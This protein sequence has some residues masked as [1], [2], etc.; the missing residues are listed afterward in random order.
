MQAFLFLLG[1]ARK[2]QVEYY[3]LKY[4]CLSLCCERRGDYGG[5]LLVRQTK[6]LRQLVK[7]S[8]LLN[9][10]GSF[11]CQIFRIVEQ[12]KLAFSNRSEKDI[13]T[14]RQGLWGFGWD[15]V[16]SVGRPP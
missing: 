9:G 14:V 6:K 2:R 13:F 16:M 4:M 10:S 15:A 3:Q 12:L 1:S 5:S 8:L 11:L 7:K